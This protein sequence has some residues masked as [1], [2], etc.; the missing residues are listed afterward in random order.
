MEKHRTQ[1]SCVGGWPE[2]G[3]WLGKGQLAT[4]SP[5]MSAFPT[6]A[7]WPVSSDGKRAARWKSCAN[8]LRLKRRKKTTNRKLEALPESSQLFGGAR[9]TRSP[10]ACEYSA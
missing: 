4:K 2:S 8:A 7:T 1:L 3:N 10:K 6:A 5:R 9:V